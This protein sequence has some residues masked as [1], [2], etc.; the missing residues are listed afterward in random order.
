MLLNDEDSIWQ[1]VTAD[2]IIHKNI[3]MLLVATSWFC[4]GSSQLNCNAINEAGYHHQSSHNSIPYG[5]K[6]TSNSWGYINNYIHIF[7]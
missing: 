4:K 1:Q 2:A 7:H 5:P 6:M 3:I